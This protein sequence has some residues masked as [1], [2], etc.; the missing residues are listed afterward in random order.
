MLLAVRPVSAGAAM[1]TPAGKPTTPIPRSRPATT[2]PRFTRTHMSMRKAPF[3]PRRRPQWRAT[4]PRFSLRG[5]EFRLVFL[6][7]YSPSG[8]RP[9]RRLPSPVCLLRGG[10]MN[11]VV[12]SCK[13]HQH[14]DD[15]EPNAETD[16]LGAFRKRSPPYC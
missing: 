7:F 5:I 4:G 6:S 8:D 13:Y 15:C 1:A 14:D 11:D 9:G 16:L 2:S 3:T 10:Q 12:E